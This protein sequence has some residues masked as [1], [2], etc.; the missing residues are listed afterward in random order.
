MAV[1]NVKKSNLAAVEFVS[2]NDD[3]LDLE[4]SKYEDFLKTGKLEHLVYLPGRV[5]TVF[6]CNFALKAR[7]ASELKDAIMA[8]RD[9]KGRP[10][11]ALGH[12]AFQTVKMTLKDIKNPP[13]AGDE[14]FI[15]RKDKAGLADDEL[16][17][18]LNAAGI[19]DEIFAFYNELVG[20]GVKD[21]A[22]N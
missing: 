8:G 19:A 7:E 12:W 1:R 10:T 16:I 5:P 18:E 21:N 20:G 4:A 6:V 3:A 13:E 9:A 14:G 17:G 22:K 11:V 15:F 2:S